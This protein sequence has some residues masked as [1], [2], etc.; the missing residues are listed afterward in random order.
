MTRRSLLASLVAA[1]LAKLWPKKFASS[2]TA[3]AAELGRNQALTQAAYR[4]YLKTGDRVSL[5]YITTGYFQPQIFFSI[6]PKHPSMWP[7]PSDAQVA[8]NRAR[9][10]QRT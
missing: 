10:F 4:A 9:Y 3:R 2:M 1:P 6:R 8:E 7:W 5:S